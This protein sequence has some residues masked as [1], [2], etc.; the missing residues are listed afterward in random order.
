MNLSD[1][2]VSCECTEHNCQEDVIVEDDEDMLD[3]VLC[4]ECMFEHTT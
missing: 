3:I 1:W 2:L 4:E